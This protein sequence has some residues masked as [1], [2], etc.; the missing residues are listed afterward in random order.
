MLEINTTSKLISIAAGEYGCFRVDAYN[1]ST[2]TLYQPTAEDKIY[3]TVKKTT[4]RAEKALISKLGPKVELLGEDTQDL[5]YGDY[6]YDVELEFADGR[7]VKIVSD[8]VFRVTPTV[9]TPETKGA[10]SHGG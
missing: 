2:G 3:F 9:T 8:K 10:L 4:D 1:E 7:A 6:H 5:P